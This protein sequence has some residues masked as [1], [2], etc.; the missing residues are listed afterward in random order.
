MTGAMKMYGSA[1]KKSETP[2]K[3]SIRLVADADA[4]SLAVDY[5]PFITSQ[6]T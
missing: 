3:T 1:Q 4:F 5:S 2:D 6:L